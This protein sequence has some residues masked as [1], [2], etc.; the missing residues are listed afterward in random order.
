[1]LNET[2]V[3]ILE[4]F[5]DVP[6]SSEGVIGALVLWCFRSFRFSFLPTRPNHTPFR[7][8][9]VRLFGALV[10]CI[11]PTTSAPVGPTP[12]FYFELRDRIRMSSAALK[13]LWSFLGPLGSSSFQK[14]RTLELVLQKDN[15]SF[16]I[17]S[18]PP[19][20]VLFFRSFLKIWHR[21]KFPMV[22]WCFGALY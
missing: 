9:L 16:R 14:R 4:V 3:D 10:L 15:V 6:A 11:K 18:G 13:V 22:L 21:G 20:P 7:V 2:H 17:T 5:P 12:N 19:I 8:A 1:M